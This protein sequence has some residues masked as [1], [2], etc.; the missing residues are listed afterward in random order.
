MTKQEYLNELKY[1]L[2]TLPVEEQEEALE[3]YRGYFEEANNDNE[4]MNEFGSPEELAQTIVSK[5][6]SVPAKCIKTPNKTRDGTGTCFSN[7]E[8]RSLDISLGAAEVVM[9]SGENFSI[10]YRGIEPGDIL[11]GLSPFGTLS[12]QNTTKIPNM[13]FWKHHDSTGHK[14]NHPRILIRIP[15]ETKLDLLKLHIGAG[16]F[17][18]K[19]IAINSARS[20][21]DVGAGNIV[22][23][24]IE[25]G[26]AELKC[27]MGNLEFTGALEGLIKIDCGMGNVA[28]NLSGNPE[29][30]SFS[31]KVGLGSIIF[32]SLRKDGIGKIDSQVQ[33]QNHFSVNCGIGCVKIKMN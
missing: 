23:N 18:G 6:A 11:Y 15:K 5:F 7:D 17:S 33:K 25:G 13:S 30:Y 22:L 24:K 21:I 29:G 26:V 14:T 1:Q 3:Y 8:V 10:D 16:S 9:I 19:K 12:I 32:N 31:G 20:Y 2:R 27:G 28:L 4:V